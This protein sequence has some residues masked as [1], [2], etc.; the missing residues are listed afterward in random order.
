MS[1]NT[2]VPANAQLGNAPLDTTA[3]YTPK[4]TK[5]RMKTKFQK[6]AGRLRLCLDDGDARTGWGPI[7]SLA[8]QF[9]Q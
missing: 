3:K 6:F 5:T 1:F 4:L 7:T 9:A 2:I 8:P